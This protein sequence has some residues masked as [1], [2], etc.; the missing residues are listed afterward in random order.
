MDGILNSVDG[1]AG[2][3]GDFWWAPLAVI[4]VGV[5]LALPAREARGRSAEYAASSRDYVHGP[6]LSRNPTS[7]SM[8]RTAISE[9][10]DVGIPASGGA[11]S[12]ASAE[13]DLTHEPEA[14]QSSFVGGA[15]GL[16]NSSLWR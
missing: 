3:I 15:E 6:T 4:E 13:I 1:E 12:S 7:S 14:G 5:L 9:R 10:A 8:S 16:S 2:L 11:G